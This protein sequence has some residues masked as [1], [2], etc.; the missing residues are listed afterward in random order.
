MSDAAIPAAC[1]ANIG[2][3]GIRL[4]RRIGLA[5]FL[6]GAV[7]G[8]VLVLTGAPTSWRVMATAPFFVG[9]LGWLQAR[10][11]TCV[12]L[13]GRHLRD[14]D[15]EPL[16]AGIDAT[17][18]DAAVRRRARGIRLKALGL[19]IVLTAVLFAIPPHA[20]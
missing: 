6:A 7:F 10:E 12:S 11:R 13:A 9:A 15:A 14:D 17:A 2:P 3:R 8:L 18:L 16:P 19:A 5:G 4:R 20:P 1:V